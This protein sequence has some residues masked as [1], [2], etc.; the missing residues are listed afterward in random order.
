MAGRTITFT[1]T[2]SSSSHVGA[3]DTP[4]VYLSYPAADSDPT[5]PAKV[6]RSFAKVC[7]ATSTITYTASDRDVSNWDVSAKEWT[8]TKGTY[9]ISVGASS[10]DI[11]LTGHLDV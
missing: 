4:Q 8:V 7:D 6:L 9:G 2:R 5:V 10:Q 3:C 1:V 11:R